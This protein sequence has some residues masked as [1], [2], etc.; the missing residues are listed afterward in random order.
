M[1]NSNVFL[2]NHKKSKPFFS[3]LKLAFLILPLICFESAKKKAFKT[4]KS[5][6][7]AK[8][9]AYQV[10][11]QDQFWTLEACY[12]FYPP[13]Y[14]APECTVC[15]GL[16]P[17]FKSILAPKPA[18]GVCL[19]PFLFPPKQFSDCSFSPPNLSQFN[20]L[21]TLDQPLQSTVADA[22]VVLI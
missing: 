19:A 22:N 8:Q 20:F 10:S 18:F 11:L 2:L 6:Q 14:F 4:I 12:A 15:Y 17:S 13:H 9:K 21:A 16:E 3:P 7:K 5:K 1:K